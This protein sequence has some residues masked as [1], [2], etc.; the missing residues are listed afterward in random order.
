MESLPRHQCLIY[1]GP[2]SRQLPALVAVTLEKL[3][4]NH[5]CLY[6]NS[7]TMVAGMRS[8]LAAAGI[9]VAEET[10][11]GSLVASSEQSLG[12]GYEFKVEIMI[13]GLRAALDRALDDGY[14]GLWATGDMAWEF[15]P[16][17]DFSRLLEYEWRLEEFLA[18]N[19][20]MGGICQYRADML[21]RTAMR[22]AVL[23]HRGIFVNETL[24]L[25][26]P[27]YL[28][29]E[30]FFDEAAENLELDSCINKLIAQEA[31]N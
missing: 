29:P 26:N 5:R 14:S 19:P 3:Q 25:L 9:D 24:S 22:H 16:Q 7:P 13:D 4:Q 21:P 8:Y 1:E 28:P 12:S 18:S 6:L 2:P 17:R 11:R 31:L 20:Q 27:Q 30:R 23:S 15:G 10:A